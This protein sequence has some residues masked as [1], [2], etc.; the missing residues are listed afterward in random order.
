MADDTAPARLAN[1][2]HLARAQGKLV[3]FLASLSNGRGSSGL[4]SLQ[5]C[6]L[7]SL[8]PSRKRA[9]AKGPSWPSGR[10]PSPAPVGG[11]CS[12]PRGAPRAEPLRLTL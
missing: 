6:Y 4:S 10:G 5:T 2:E 12:T 8:R 9:R 7:C 3:L 11:L 1:L